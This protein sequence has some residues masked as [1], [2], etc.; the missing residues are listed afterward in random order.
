M[1]KSE[2]KAR[3]LLIQSTIDIRELS[4]IHG[5]VDLSSIVNEWKDILKELKNDLLV[6]EGDE[7]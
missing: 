7:K 6:L 2:I 3:C 4:A 1:G 5:K